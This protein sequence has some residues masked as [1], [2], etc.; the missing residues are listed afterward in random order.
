[1]MIWRYGSP[2]GGHFG[3]QEGK[4]GGLLRPAEPAPHSDQSSLADVINRVARRWVELPDE[5]PI[6]D[7]GR[8]RLRRKG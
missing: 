8:R 4:Q 1:M 5:H 3:I 2:Q 6:F 7:P